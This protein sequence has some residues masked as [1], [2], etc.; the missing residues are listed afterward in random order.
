MLQQLRRH[1]TVVFV[2]LIVK[3]KKIV[4]VERIPEPL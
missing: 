4:D 3:V 1:V 2:V